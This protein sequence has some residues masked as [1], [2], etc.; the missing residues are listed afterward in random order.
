M[1][2]SLGVESFIKIGGG[3]AG[4]LVELSRNDHSCECVGESG[5]RYAAFLTFGHGV[6]ISSRK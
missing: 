1:Y 4:R 3:R 2:P 6:I 5:V